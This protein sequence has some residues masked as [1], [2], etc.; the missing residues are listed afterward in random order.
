M[1]LLFLSVTR[2]TSWCFLIFPEIL[3]SVSYK[4]FI[5][6]YTRCKAPPKHLETVP[7]HNHAPGFLSKHLGV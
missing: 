5:I 3:T 6:N 7:N 4:V 2:W 1:D